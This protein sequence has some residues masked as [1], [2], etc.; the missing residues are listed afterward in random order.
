MNN[1][2]LRKA[3]RG[4][5]AALS[6]AMVLSG[7]PVLGGMEAQAGPVFQTELEPDV[8][9]M[10][11]RPTSA[12]SRP[13]YYDPSGQ[14][15]QKA[16]SYGNGSTT[17]YKYGY[18]KRGASGFDGWK[19]DIN[20]IIE[21]VNTEPGDELQ[22]S[23]VVSDRAQALSSTY[24]TGDPQGY[25]TAVGFGATQPS[26][27]LDVGRVALKRSEYTGPA[28][29]F[30]PGKDGEIK[31]GE[32]VKVFDSDNTTDLKLEIRLSV[33][34]SPDKKYILAEYTVHNANTNIAETNPKIRDNG[35][36][37]GGRT[38]W[39]ATG[40]DIMV[41][42]DDSAPAWATSKGASDGRHIEGIHAQGNNS[43]TYTLG[44]LDILSY[45][46]QLNLGIQ[47]KRDASDPSKITSWIGHY[48]Q[49]SSNYF[50][51]LS[52]YSYMPGG[53]QGSLD[54]GIAY[55]LKF[56][57]LPGETKTGTIAFSMR[58][59]T[60]YV[61]PVGG[62]DT[63]G[64]GFLSSPFK[65]T[66]K[67]L[68]KIASRSP[69]KV[70]V[71]LMN[72]EEIDYP[73]TIPAGKDVTIQTTD[74]VMDSS[75]N[76]KTKPYP[77]D[78]D[79]NG[80]RT[81]SH[82]IKRAPNYKGDM[83][84]VEHANSNLTLSDIVIEGNKAA[85]SALPKN[86]QPTGSLVK[87][88]AGN[89]MTQKGAIL[90]NNKIVPIG[91]AFTDGNGD[92]VWNE[93]EAFTDSNGNSQYDAVLNGSVASAID[94]SGT[95]NLKMDN[96]VIKDNESYQGGAVNFDGAEFMVG[97]AVTIFDN[98]ND[99]GGKSNANLG[100]GKFIK[101]PEPLTGSS[102][103]GVSTVDTPAN[104]NAEIL[105]ADKD[106]MHS[107]LPYS[108]SNFPADRGPAQWTQMGTGGNANK[109]V[110]KATQA[111][112]SVSYVYQVK[113]AGGVV[114]SENTVH[115]A[116]NSN[117]MAGTAINEMPETV[118]TYVFDKVEISPA[119]GHGLSVDNT[120]G[121]V[122]GAMP[123]MDIS[124]K[125]IYVKDVGTAYF[126]PDGGTP[127]S[128]PPIESTAGLPPSASM[129]IVTRTG[130]NFM[131]W[132]E[133]TNKGPDDTYGTADD[134]LASAPSPALP[135]PVQRGE[136]YY[137][138]VWQVDGTGYLFEITH[139]NSNA[140][141]PL[142]F[143]IIP[144]NKPYLDEVRADKQNIPGYLHASSSAN[145]AN[146]G[147]FGGTFDGLNANTPTEYI[148]RMPLGDQK[149]NFVYRVDPTQTFEFKVE[150]KS[151]GGSDVGGAQPA[152]IRRP[153]ETP[154]H[155][156][157][158]T[159]AGYSVQSA[160]I[161]RGNTVMDYWVTFDTISGPNAIDASFNMSGYMP[162]QDVTLTYIYGSTSGYEL[163]RRYMDATNN[164][165][166]GRATSIRKDENDP[167]NEPAA[168]KYGYTHASSALNPAV[169]GITV[170]GDGSI[171]GVMPP[172]DVVVT[173]TMNRDPAFWK[174]ITFAVGNA[175]HNQGMIPAST[176]IQFLM[177]DP[178][179][180]A[181]EPE[182]HTFA[183]IKR[184]NAASMPT[185]AGNPTPYYMWDGKWYTDA[186]CTTEVTDA[187]TF[188]GDT[189]LY[190]KFVEDPNHWVDVNFAAGANGSISSLTPVHT[191]KG[192]TWNDIA[193]Q[194]PV[195]VVPNTTPN[196][197]FDKW[198]VNGTMVDDSTVLIN[199]ATYTANFKKD[200]AAWGLNMGDFT[201]IGHVSQDG[202]GE[203]VV[204][205][206]QAGNVYVIS[207]M[208]GN[209]VDVI[210][211]PADGSITFRDL[212]PG[213]RYNVQEGTPDTVAVKGQPISTISGS[214]VSAPKEVLIPT[215]EDNYAVGIDPNNEG[216]AQIVI[217]PADPDSDYALIDENGNIVPYPTANNG[218]MTPV[219]SNPS[220]VTFDN[221]NPGGT[222]RVVARKK[223][224]NSVPS[225]LDKFNEGTDIT[226]NPG[227]MLEA[228]NFVVETKGDVSSVVQTVA[229]NAVNLSRFDT[230]RPGDLV[231]IHTDAVNAG[232]QAFKYW[233]VIAGRNPGVVGRITS[234]D[235]SF[236]MTANNLVLRAVYERP[237]TVPSNANSEEEIRGGAQGEFGLDPDSIEALEDALT[238]PD[239][240]VLMDINGADV[241]YRIVFNKRN[242][243]T[244]EVSAVKPVSISGSNHSDA[245]SA[246]W[247]LD[248][249]AER[250][251]DGRL[252]GRATPSNATT[253]VIIQLP[254]EDTDM[255][256]YELFDVT[257]PTTPVGMT[258]MGDP[259]QNAGLF[260]FN[261][262]IGHSYV[263]VYSK[264]FK[265]RFL[266]NNPVLDFMHLN[267]VSRNFYHV[268]KIR[269]KEAPTDTWYDTPQLWRAA[270][271]YRD[272]LYA[273][274][275]S[276]PT[277]QN[278]IF[279]EVNFADIYGVEYSFIDWSRKNMPENIQ[280]FDPDA[281]VTRPMVIYAYYKDNR[282][283]VNRARTKLTGLIGEAEAL[284]GDPYLNNSEIDMLKDAIAAAKARIDQR[285][286]ELLK[287]DF[288]S[289][290]ID[291]QRMAIYEEL[292]KAIDDLEALMRDL[293]GR[294]DARNRRFQGYTGGSG[295]GGSGSSGKG[296]GNRNRPLEASGERTFTL[297]VDGNWKINPATGKWS[298][299]LN[300][301]LPLNNAWGKIQFANAEGK[302]ITK[303]YFFD[304]QSAMVTGWYHDQKLDKWYFLNTAEGA[305]SGQLLKGWFLDKTS[306]LWYYLDPVLGEMYIG[307]CRIGDKWYYFEPVGRDG[308]PKGSLY[309]S[310]T[311][312][313]GYQVNHNG[314]WVN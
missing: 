274:R 130:Y 152:P 39:F 168:S 54:S 111:A 12:Y 124:I 32:V 77:I 118:A 301:G 204:R 85:T 177:D 175:P 304:H 156:S 136:K 99:A 127:G 172:N 3:R 254:G 142:T 139:K 145:P 280:V 134:T 186:G 166:I 55:S 98:V 210:T 193:A 104:A 208:N 270:R 183:D 209:I 138:A 107:A 4:L 246:A 155:A 73:I 154:I 257:N 295:G 292:K 311:T 150:H 120:S 201:P 33:K 90:Q 228:Q 282:A 9:L 272:S 122:V 247:G 5:A 267:D 296:T 206:T 241:T 79:G 41:A 239:D 89:V 69:K 49:Y 268:M 19:F 313:D 64:T 250:Y 171:S 53:T 147:Q 255:L 148:G 288:G 234:T 26:S 169:P 229:G 220:T 16:A 34:P 13:H 56:D 10:E 225:P 161:T 67:A 164:Q 221:L 65:T 109:V 35:R 123:G 285:R 198:T 248:V 231:E 28:A 68:E 265:L 182:A 1:K 153:A 306:N 236:T 259:E 238:T 261:A 62:S 159:V 173:H 269:R 17:S 52:D 100:T 59:P 314:E 289:G 189:V 188:Q 309:I 151:T 58:G 46:P 126:F 232:G 284:A 37:D 60:Y 310:T 276:R 29:E 163:A 84:V 7:L 117:L 199:G 129:P 312:P 135:S 66:K 245:F 187:T 271:D 20:G 88:T 253:N 277:E 2:F 57:L 131:G 114:V 190:A 141:L 113:D 195:P 18:I 179:T 149:L 191:W 72:D 11:G 97:N 92:G 194:R 82:K 6:A 95:A 80:E 242:A 196:Y 140:S 240:E 81:N 266:D 202:S 305:D 291:P 165:P 83:I 94:I 215:V 22:E 93:G 278:G 50:T 297:G 263:L 42:G 160:T 212:Y 258:M 298:F 174:H 237:T 51:D 226:A 103:I 302:L 144:D 102:K 218:W 283:E 181:V 192:H 222:Y 101:V 211:S 214:Q 251:V 128:I 23:Y 48:R 294:I 125:Y 21:P 227:D 217:N 205:D 8:N 96:G 143:K 75:T 249:I 223:G 230:A 216:M 180:A 287:Y 279:W 219:G 308:R 184:L 112:Y 293:L 233:K 178:M 213:T 87:A 121:R 203:V 286:G 63:S 224:D 47:P 275:Q 76:A 110:L 108:V 273:G 235:F 61:D 74:Y 256:D 307:W 43:N 38:V 133:I 176:P 14:R 185:P 170:A 299:V 252:V 200:P 157:P 260:S 70:F 137:K 197:V 281:Q 290:L 24:P 36:A 15:L 91:E 31:N 45:H 115:T 106:G 146:K 158:R 262:T 78:V 40:T 105:V 119:A 300:G 264:A 167:I 132:F 44:A 303:W 207:D 244:N 86:Q 30:F 116:K 27:F 243:K 71:F 25:T 162:N